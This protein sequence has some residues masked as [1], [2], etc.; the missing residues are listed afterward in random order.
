MKEYFY[1]RG[2]RVVTRREYTGIAEHDKPTTETSNR[3]AGKLRASDPDFF[4]TTYEWNDDSLMTRVVHPNGN[5]TEMVYETDLGV[6]GLVVDEILDVFEADLTQGEPADR[7][8]LS[9]TGIIGRRATDLLDVDEI[10]GIA[11]GSSLLMGA[12]SMS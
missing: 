1:D 4:E 3:P 5:I 12:G 8:G 6:Y 10:I 7:T 11:G 9:M 2:N